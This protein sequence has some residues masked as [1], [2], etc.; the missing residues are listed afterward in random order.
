MGIEQK[1]RRVWRQMLLTGLM[2]VAGP[3]AAQ[4]PPYGPWGTIRLSGSSL[5]DA[6][7]IT[8]PL[9]KQGADTSFVFYTESEWYKL[10]IPYGLSGA[11]G[12]RGFSPGDSVF[13][14]M[15]SGGKRYK[16]FIGLW[17][18]GQAP[19]IDINFGGQDIVTGIGDL[20]Q[21]AGPEGYALVQN[22]PNPFN[23]MT[24]I[25]YTLPQRDDVR[26]TIYDIRGR[27]V[28]TLAE[29][30]LPAGEYL[31]TWDGTNAAGQQ[32]ASGAYLYQI[33]TKRYAESKKMLLL[34]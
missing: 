19:R 2:A 30:T 10:T 6:T 20:V 33:R 13:L 11:G 29:R 26:I 17:Q 21:Q 14:R 16:R 18:G 28:K 4:S 24:Q 31:L 1:I 12:S 25:R 22:C 8:V 34:R 9:R 23:A 5:P 32:V 27:K 15:E 7:Q 3:A